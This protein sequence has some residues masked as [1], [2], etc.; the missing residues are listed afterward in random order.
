[1]NALGTVSADAPFRKSGNKPPR[2]EI[3]RRDD[4]AL[5]LRNPHPLLT[6]PENLIAPLLRSC[7]KDSSRWHPLPCA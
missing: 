3:E 6:P 4:G 2:V 1:M 5:I 7:H